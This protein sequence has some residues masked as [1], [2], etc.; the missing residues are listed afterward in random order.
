MAKKGFFRKLADTITSPIKKATD[1]VTRVV[2]APFTKKEAPKPKPAPKPKTKK[3]RKKKA[4][5]VAPPKPAPPIASPKP[6][7]AVARQQL[8]TKLQDMY[9]L[10]KK[11]DAAAMSKRIDRM[12]DD[13]VYAALDM[14]ENDIETTARMKPT[15]APE[16]AAPDDPNANMLWYHG[17]ETVVG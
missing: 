14:S 17:G 2:A 11:W 9:W 6:T 12:T 13:Q 1:S 10:Q 7:P 16:W 5:P 3:W 8:H 4:A 15:Q